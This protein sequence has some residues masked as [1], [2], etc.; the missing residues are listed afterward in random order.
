MLTQELLNELREFVNKGRI[1]DFLQLRG[2]AFFIGGAAFCL[3]PRELSK[4]IERNRQLTFNQTLFKYIDK[5]EVSDIDIYK[6]AGIDRRHFSKIRS[7]PDYRPSKK[8]CI[9]LAL[10]LELDRADAY[11]LLKSA[12]Y[13]LSGADTFDLIIE[14]R[15]ENNVY[16]IDDV[17]IALDDFSLKPL[18]AI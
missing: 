6:K 16:D 10:A 2:S 3:K 9:A 17:N 7:N 15:F 18:I 1:K 11:K 12:G 4:F 8:T 13:S 5:K 14:F